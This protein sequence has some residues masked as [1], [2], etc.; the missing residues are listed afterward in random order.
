[1]GAMLYDLLLIVA[2]LFAVSYVFLLLTGG[3]AISASS[4]PLL[5]RVYQLTLL[6]VIVLFFGFFWTRRGGQTLGMV[7]WRLQVARDDGAPFTW[8][9]TLKRLAGALVSWAA[10]GL[11]YFWLWIDRDRLTWHDRWTRTRVVVLPKRS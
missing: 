10:L 8:A 9:D 7:A 1:M 2:L 11:G 6:G 3:E 4:H 5:E